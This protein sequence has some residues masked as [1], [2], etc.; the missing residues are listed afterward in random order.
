MYLARSFTRRSAHSGCT[1]ATAPTTASIR[2][3]AVTETLPRISP[4]AGS[5]AWRSACAG[6]SLTVVLMVNRLSLLQPTRPANLRETAR[7]LLLCLRRLIETRAVD[8]VGE[9]LLR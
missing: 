7:E 4:V 5:R 2:S 8:A 3:G 1:L 9:K 6:G